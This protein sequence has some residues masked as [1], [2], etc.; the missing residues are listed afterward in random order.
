MAFNSLGAKVTAAIRKSKD[1]AYV[2]KEKTE[3][4]TAYRRVVSLFF[5]SFTLLSEQLFIE[6]GSGMA[7]QP[8]LTKSSARAR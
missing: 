5:F 2:A 3:L 7:P 4:K 8:S 1:L 6:S